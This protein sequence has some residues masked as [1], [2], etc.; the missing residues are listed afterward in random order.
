MYFLTRSS[1]QLRRD[2]E[3]SELEVMVENCCSIEY[4]ARIIVRGIVFI[5]R[6]VD[7]RFIVL[8]R[9]THL[10]MLVIAFLI[11]M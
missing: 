6:V 7:P 4:V 9:H 8:R 10:G 11:F 2:M 5:I 1:I 3:S